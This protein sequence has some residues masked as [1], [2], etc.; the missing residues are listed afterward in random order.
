MKLLKNIFLWST[1]ILF[2]SSSNCKKPLEQWD[3]IKV[4]NNSNITVF[5]DLQFNFP[6]TALHLAG[7]NTSFGIVV[8]S[9]SDGAFP[10]P[11]AGRW[12]AEINSRNP[13]STVSFFF[14]SND[15][16]NKYGWEVIRQNYLIL[17]RKEM[18]TADLK[19]NQWTVS[20]P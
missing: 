5:C 20:F 11:G 6:D 17:A 14:I 3:Y 9:S 19:N 2:L 16:L 4:I 1:L 8:N 15:T 13:N 18:N 12:E 7:D 10:M